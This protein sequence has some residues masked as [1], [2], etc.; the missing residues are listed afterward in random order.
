[1]F[2]IETLSLFLLYQTKA[3]QAFLKKTGAADVTHK[4]IFPA[5]EDHQLQ[6]NRG[7]FFLTIPEFELYSMLIEGLCILLLMMGKKQET[8]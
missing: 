7:R 2:S 3:E 1:M 6:C 8:I 5:L 4:C